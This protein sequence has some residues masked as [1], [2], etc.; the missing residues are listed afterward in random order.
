VQLHYIFSD[1]K[2]VR[3]AKITFNG[4]LQSDCVVANDEKGY[5]IRH[6]KKGG[7]VTGRETLYGEVIIELPADVRG[8]PYRTKEKSCKPVT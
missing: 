2:A 7:A 8:G 6:V 1:Q 4:K 3:S 5:I